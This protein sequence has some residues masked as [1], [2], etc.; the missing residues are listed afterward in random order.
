MSI[1]KLIRRHGLA[2]ALLIALWAL[3]FWRTITPVEVDKLSFTQGDFSG[4][5]F[6][7]AS[8]QYERFAAGE[9]PLWNPYNNGGLPFIGDTQSAVF[10]PPRLLT[11]AG[12]WLSG[13]WSYHALE[14]EVI[15]HVLAYTLFM[16]IFVLRLT[17]S[18]HAGLASAVIAGYGGFLTGYAP[19]QLAILEAGVWLPVAALG[20][21]TA[22]TGEKIRLIPLVI[23]G[24]GLGMSWLAGHPQTSFLL[25]YLLIAYFGFGIYIRR[26][27][28]HRFV[29]GVGLFGTITFGMVA[30]QFL[31]GIEYL[32]HTTRIGF[33]YDAKANGFPLQDVVQF[34]LPGILSQWSPL[35]IGIAGLILA[36]IGW[37][38]RGSN[39]IFWGAVAVIG[40]L[41]SFGGNGAVFPALYNILPGLSFFRGQERA[42]YLVA[43]GLAILAGVGV[44][45]L[46]GWDLQTHHIAG[47]RLRL[48]LNRV[49]TGALM[50]G[51]LIFVTWIGNPAAYGLTLAMVVLG[52]LVVIM[53]YVLISTGTTQDRHEILLWGL[54]AII[55]LELFTVNMGDSDVYDPIPPSQQ[56]SLTPPPL[57]ASVLADE[58]GVFR[59]DGIR[60][61]TA[62]YGSLYRVQDIRGISPLWLAEPYQLVEGGG[63][64][65][66]NAW[67]LFA[68]RYVLTDW[69]E[70]PISSTLIETG[71]DRYGAIN[72]HRLSDP[73]PFALFMPTVRPV[74]H[75]DEALALMQSGEVNLRDTLILET[76]SATEPNEMGTSAQATLVKFSPEQI[77][78]TLISDQ[79]AALSIALPY[80]PGW[81]ATLDG[82]PTE[83]LRAYGA[84][85]AVMVP[86]GEHTLQLL[87]NP[88]SYRVG[89]VISSM[90]GLLLGGFAIFVFMRGRTRHGDT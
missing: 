7:F 75:A 21:L 16:Y 4:Q 20:I 32:S 48:V 2:V 72:L 60:G 88:L 11:L 24:F 90:T 30:V 69:A 62:N 76:T 41:W 89:A 12:A 3:F 46:A 15:A 51:A 22:T 1:N 67:E 43:N 19:L 44:A 27:R 49:M 28:W 82:Q 29:V 74:A 33:G 31:P 10:Y 9:V 68:V 53:L 86:A 5:F 84:L 58:D 55:V 18:S 6:T 83:R 71:E 81:E 40:L 8:Y 42:A 65:N 56:V 85:T 63:F 50:F 23:T 78:M 57:I 35:Y 34:L 59:V 36:L 39:A 87:Y 37:W 13:G 45:A 17:G 26:G 66:P 54:V 79:A 38:R 14:L 25:T 77:I 70:L 47:L 52:V 80:Y 61:L 73:R 64:P